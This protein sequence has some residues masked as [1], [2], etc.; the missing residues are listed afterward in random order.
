MAEP[1]NLDDML[2]QMGA[3]LTPDD[4]GFTGSIWSTIA[5]FFTIGFASVWSGWLSMWEKALSGFWEF[6]KSEVSEVNVNDWK[7]ILD[8]AVEAKMMPQEAADRIMELTKTAG[9]FGIVLYL[10]FLLKYVGNYAETFLEGGTNFVR[11][12]LNKGIRPNLPDG[13]SVLNAAFIAPEKTGEVRE[14][15][16]EMGLSDDHIDLMFLSAYQLYPVQV[17]QDLFLR[18]AIDEETMMTRM[19]E[20][21]FTD[22]RIKEIVQSWEVIPP[23]QDIL[24]MVGHEAFEP[25]SIAK[26]GLDS[27]YPDEQTK[28]GAKQGLSDYWMHKYWISHWQEPSIGQ[29]YEM[30]QRGV[31]DKETLEFLYR[32]VEIPPYWRDKLT[33]I[34]YNPY[35]R[36]DVRRMHKMG[37]LSDEELLRAYKD[38]GYNDEHAE[39]MALFTVKYNQGANKGATKGEILTAYKEDL[40][41]RNDAKELLASLDYGDAEAEFVLILTDYK[42]DKKVHDDSVK[43]IG[44]QYKEGLIE[45]FQARDSLGRLNLSSEQSSL[46][47]D[48]WGLDKFRARKEPSK[49]DLIMMLKKGVIDREQFAMELRNSGYGENYVQ[50]YIKLTE[51][52]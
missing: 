26:M 30:L 18:E 5:N 34:A 16:K 10:G 33:Q 32:T 47:M 43:L 41:T 52:E 7:Y 14:V 40:I 24:T 15:F 21:G 42:K 48:Q 19:R 27:E 12:N 17:V 36:V 22:T 1:E 13:L 8:H 38:I 44:K 28:W 49:T 3:P 37:V 9:A 2:K 35:S 29:G 46:L 39:K 45:D 6:F 50:W 4:G 20:L 25:D 11:R 23:I 31:I 51:T